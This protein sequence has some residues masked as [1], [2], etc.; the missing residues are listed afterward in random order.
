MYKN[1]LVKS[2]ISLHIDSTDVFVSMAIAGV[3]ALD[4]NP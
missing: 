4:N 3:V 2:E 1:E